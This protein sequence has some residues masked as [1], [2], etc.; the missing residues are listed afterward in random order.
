MD[1]TSFIQLNIIIRIKYQC[2]GKEKNWLALPSEIN[3]RTIGN[4]RVYIRQI[5][6]WQYYLCI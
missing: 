5:C 1:A 6:S 4:H 2:I 3:R